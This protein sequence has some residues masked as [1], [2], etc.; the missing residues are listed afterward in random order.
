MRTGGDALSD[1]HVPG[2]CSREAAGPADCHGEEEHLEE[3]GRA[4]LCTALSCNPKRRWRP[5]GSASRRAGVSRQAAEFGEALADAIAQRE[6]A[7]AMSCL[8]HELAAA[9]TEAGEAHRDPGG[10]TRCDAGEGSINSNCV[11][12]E[13]GKIDFFG[14]VSLCLVCRKV[15]L[16]SIN[17]ARAGQISS[18]ARSTRTIH[19]SRTTTNQQ[20]SH[21]GIFER[22]TG[23]FMYVMLR[24][25]QMP[26]HGSK[27]TTL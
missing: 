4:K 16:E 27:A 14:S 26:Y 12:K 22:N 21:M 25:H 15:C 7:G 3:V 11:S 19:A 9:R 6:H 10:R 8:E 5:Q 20:S 23:M 13:N 17:T 18:S 2:C 1:D 24:Q